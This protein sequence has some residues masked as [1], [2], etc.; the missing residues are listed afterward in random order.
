MLIRCVISV[1]EFP[2]SSCHFARNARKTRAIAVHFFF[3]FR[4]IRYCYLQPARIRD[5]SP[6]ILIDYCNVR[7]SRLPL[8]DSFAFVER[9][10]EGSFQ[11][12]AQLARVTTASRKRRRNRLRSCANI[13]VSGPTDVML[14]LVLSLEA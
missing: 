7:S 14:V 4:T 5:N 12:Y 1:E 2:V 13:C 11:F 9:K 8:S 6:R 3:P 10:I